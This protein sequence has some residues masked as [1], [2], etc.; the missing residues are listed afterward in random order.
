NRSPAHPSRGYL[1]GRYAREKATSTQMAA[2]LAALERGVA[3]AAVLEEGLDRVLQVLGRK[4]VG[5]LGA[6]HLV[7]RRDPALAGALQH[8]LRQRMRLGRPRRQLLGECSGALLELLGGVELVDHA[9]ALHL[10]RR[11]DPAAHHE[12]AR[13]PG[14]GP[15]GESLGP[16]HR[17]RQADHYL[18]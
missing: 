4:E 2:G 8:L 6:D 10:L 7:G 18:D 1:F 15:L 14:A 11:E 3:W 5:R 12:L 13:A 9:P 16:A 17:G